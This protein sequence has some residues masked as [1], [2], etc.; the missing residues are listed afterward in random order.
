MAEKSSSAP[1]VQLG[2]VSGNA[3]APGETAS[4]DKIR[5]L[6]FGNQMQD[7]DQRFE[8]LETSLM[9]RMKEIESEAESNI[10]EFE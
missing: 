9:E 1:V 6:L 3:D 5:D 8:K 2:A 4:V 10:G 7:Y